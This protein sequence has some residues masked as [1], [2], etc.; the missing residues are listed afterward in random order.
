M[1]ALKVRSLQALLI[2][3]VFAAISN[4]ASAQRVDTLKRKDSIPAAKVDSL[5]RLEHRPK[6]AAI[7]S[8][9]LPGL[10]QAYNHK[11]WK[12]PI[13]YAALGIT[14]DIF[15]TNT[16]TYKDLRFAY[17]AKYKASLNPPDSGDYRNIKPQ[18]LPLS[19]EALRQY[20]NQ[21]RQYIDYSAVFFVVFWGLNVVD[22]V[23][24]AHLKA[25]DIS[26]DLSMKIRPAYN[27]IA[28]AGGI[29]LVFNFRH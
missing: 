7:R 29:S 6:K 9:I 28:N 21:Y 22:A 8:A 18:Y 12:I 26:P 27:P 13:I 16:R 19:L 25:F 2:A 23:V 3:T 10:G 24:D 11:Y 1:P 5:V 20:R 17:T 15:V 4:H 14:A